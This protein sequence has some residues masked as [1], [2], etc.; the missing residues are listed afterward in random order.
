METTYVYN[1]DQQ[2][3]T[4]KTTTSSAAIMSMEKINNS[5]GEVQRRLRQRR[6]AISSPTEGETGRSRGTA[7]TA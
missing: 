4:M 6:S 2:L 5:K 3:P 7:R 1:D